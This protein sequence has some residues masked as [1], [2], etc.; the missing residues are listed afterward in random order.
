MVVPEDPAVVAP[1][2]FDVGLVV[3]VLAGEEIFEEEELVVLLPVPELPVEEVPVP[4]VLLFVL[5]LVVDGFST[6]DVEFEELLGL[7]V[8]DDA[9]VA[10]V[11]EVLFC[12]VIVELVVDAF[13]SVVAA[14]SKDK[15]FPFKHSSLKNDVEHPSAQQ[16]LMILPH[17]KPPFFLHKS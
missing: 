1:L 15:N 13:L 14:S 17:T 5:E 6:V 12:D 16:S 8:F 11:A 3:A 2:E 10:F 9:V 7:V 4:L